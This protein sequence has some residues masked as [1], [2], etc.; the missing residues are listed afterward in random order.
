MINTLS[1]TPNAIRVHIAFF[2]RR[3]NGKSSLINAFANQSVALVSDI[4]GTTTDPVYKPMEVYP[5]GPCVL[6]DTAG[7]DD[8]GTLGEMRVSKTKDILNMADI[9]VMV[10]SPEQT[11][12]GYE[13]EWLSLLSEKKCP[14]IGV[15]N[16]SDFCE[17]AL[18]KAKH[19]SD[20]TGISILPV[21]A[22][23]GDGIDGI[24]RMI[25]ETLPDNT[26]FGSITGHLC[27]EGDNVLLVMPQ[28]IQAPKGRLILPQVQ[29]IRDLLDLKAIIT[30]VT[31]DK[32]EEALQNMKNPPKLII[33][34]SQVFDYVYNRKPP[35]SMLTSFSVLL[36][37]YKGD[38][39][40]FRKGAEKIDFLTESDT[41]LIAE[42]CTHAPQTE[43]I[44]RVKIPQ[45]LR[46][47]VGENLKFEIVS[48]KDFPEDLSKYA[49]VI[50]CGACMFNRKYVLNRITACQ[51]ANVPVTNYGIAIAKIKG[52]SDKITD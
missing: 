3:N 21:S 5:I 48:G 34:D 52:I 22:K 14:V 15:M 40:E 51:N 45:M 26:A 41:V 9:A 23:T 12:F 28:D 4:A 29:V 46:K 7:F 19:I 32:L 44:G 16:K 30:S 11:E 47:I 24:R 17:N 50:H 35:E 33:T 25:A 27:K 39:D 18:K 6:I 13:K 20:L 38:I 43:D 10:F 31:A 42:A 49:L 8:A 36:A 1:E 2:G 37:R